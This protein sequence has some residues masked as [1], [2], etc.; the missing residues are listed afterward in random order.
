[1]KV[2]RAVETHVAGNA[3][4]VVFGGLGDLAVPGDTMFAKKTHMEQHQDWFRQLMLKEPR[5]GPHATVN[6]VLPPCDPRAD[7]GLIIV[8]QGPYYPPM[9]GG[10]VMSVV[11]AVLETGVLPIRTPTTNVVID[12]P[13][14]LVRARATCEGDRVTA[15]HLNNVPCFAT[16]LDATIV[17]P[18]LGEITVDVAYGGMFYVLVESAPLGL[19]IEPNSAGELVR[20]GEIIKN[21]AREQ[22]TVVHP[23]N[24]AINYLEQTLWWGPPKDSANDARN[25]VVLSTGPARPSSDD[26]VRAVLDRCPCGTGTSARMA[27]LHARGQLGVGDTFRH[28]GILDSVFEG[29]VLQTTTVGPREA[30]VPEIGGRAWITGFSEWILHDDDPYPLGFTIAD[31]WP[32][33]L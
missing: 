16:H 10:L 30:I 1:M 17:V 21:A 29:R 18:G 14:G 22:L 8:E 26:K 6:L 31:V 13:A 20:F 25:T 23:E 5:G 28:E 7:I 11:T 2:I 15:V 32:E 33:T 12:T 3:G 19:D 27:V 4:R 24:P 9:S